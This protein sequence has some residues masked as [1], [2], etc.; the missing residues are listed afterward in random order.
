LPDVPTAAELGVKDF[1]VTVFVGLYGPPKL[2]SA[3]V[4]KANAAL[5]AAL[6]DPTVSNMIKKNGDLVVGGSPDQL[7]ALTRDNFKL[8]GDVAR[9]NNIKAA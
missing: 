4:Q 9:R 8:W 2:P 6:A 5:N 7:A 3:I 1:V